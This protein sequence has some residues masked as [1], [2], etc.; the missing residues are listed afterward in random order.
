M[1]VTR[2]G[3]GTLNDTTLAAERIGETDIVIGS[4]PQ[5]A[6]LAMRCNLD[7]LA[8]LSRDGELSGVLPA[9]MATV[10]DFVAA[11]TAS[12]APS[13]GGVLDAP[14]FRAAHRL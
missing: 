14:A 6:D 10:T 1:L 4:W 5:D 7:D 8:A 3:L 13:L 2:A 11:A 9:G 12:L